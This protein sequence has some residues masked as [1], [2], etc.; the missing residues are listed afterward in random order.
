MVL[1]DRVS[2]VNCNE[3]FVNLGREAGGILVETSCA[4][5]DWIEAP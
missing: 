2:V 1:H 4:L 5:A 3:F